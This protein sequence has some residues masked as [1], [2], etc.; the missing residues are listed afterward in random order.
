[1]ISIIFYVGFLIIFLY[2]AFLKRGELN[3]IHPLLGV[4]FTIGCFIY[5]YFN[6]KFSQYHINPKVLLPD[7]LA[8]LSNL[9]VL[10]DS[11]NVIQYTNVS[12]QKWLHLKV[13]A[14]H[15]LI[16]VWE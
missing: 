6:H 5:F 12:F 16:T 1:M 2:I 15:C 10:T 9:L 7:L 14:I 11:H 8:D 4:P 13:H 3:N